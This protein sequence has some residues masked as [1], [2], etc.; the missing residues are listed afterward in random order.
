MNQKR[1][2]N[3]APNIESRGVSLTAADVLQQKFAIKFRGYDTQ[4][5]TAFLEVVARE[6]ERQMNESAR[7][8]D[9][10]MLLRR[11]AE[12]Y[13]KKED[14]I[15]SALMTV[16]K[17]VDDMKDRASREADRM[18]ADARFESERMLNENR[19]LVAMQQEEINSL[20]TNWF[21]GRSRTDSE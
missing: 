14:S 17:M 12:L 18:L 8:Y 10:L 20:K 15:N 2:V 16:Q 11:E 1:T 9:E 7:L 5:V 13:R 21:T 3:K 4:D 6:M 19:A